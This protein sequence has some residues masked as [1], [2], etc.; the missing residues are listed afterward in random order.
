MGLGF[1]AG[2]FWISKLQTVPKAPK[3]SV[4]PLEQFMVK[5]GLGLHRAH[6]CGGTA[7]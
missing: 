7:S 4:G 2:G 1:R 3:E 6:N 5:D